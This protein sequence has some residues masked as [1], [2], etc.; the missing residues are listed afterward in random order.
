MYARSTTVHGHPG[1]IDVGI[2]YVREA[3]MPSVLEMDGCIGLSMLADRESGHTIITSSWA[4]AEAM[5]RS[6]QSLEAARSR[7][8][9]ILVGSIEL[10]QWE[11]AV[12]HRHCETGHGHPSAQVVWTKGD[13]Q[14]LDRM[15]AGFR[16]TMLPVLEDLPGFCSVSLMVDRETGLCATTTNYEQRRSTHESMQEA[17]ALQQQFADAMGMQIVDVASFDLVLAHLRVPETV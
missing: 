7:T 5:H 6:A 17:V 11:I 8:A 10:Q 12:L 2:A 14:P 3:V 16:M 1:A 9:E 4:D 13:P 15:I